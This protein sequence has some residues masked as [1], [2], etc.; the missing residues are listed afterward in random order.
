MLSGNVYD[1]EPVAEYPFIKKA[2]RVW[3]TS[4]YMLSKNFAPTLLENF[5]E[6]AKKLDK[7]YDER[8]DIKK[9]DPTKYNY[10]GEYAL[11]Q[12]WTSLQKSSNWYIFEPKLGNQR[13]S[14]SDIMEGTVMYAV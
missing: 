2:V 12:Y 9:T 10:I 14:Y 8:V 3:T 6:G 11:D 13:K 5:K 7:S 1:T 4:G